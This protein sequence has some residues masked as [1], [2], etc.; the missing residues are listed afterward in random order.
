ML[1]CYCV[2][3]RK[4]CKT[5]PITEFPSLSLYGGWGKRATTSECLQIRISSTLAQWVK[6]L[7][8]ILE[9]MAENITHV[10]R[11]HT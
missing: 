9:D 8:Q 2:C 10:V 11:H 4:P 3:L 1:C 7:N 5:F 6:D